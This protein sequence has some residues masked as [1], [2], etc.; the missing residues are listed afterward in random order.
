MTLISPTGI[1]GIT[2]ITALSQSLD[3]R[4]SNASSVIDINISNRLALNINGVERVHI[5]S[6]GNVGIGTTNPTV[7]LDLGSRTDAIE[8]PQGTTAQRPSGNNPYIRYNTTN[9]ALEFYN[10]TDW[11]EIISDYFPSGSTILG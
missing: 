10:G 11:V 4:G 8:L 7:S 9:S 1:S 5:N 3:V 6:S 2:S